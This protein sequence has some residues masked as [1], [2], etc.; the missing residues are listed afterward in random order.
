MI[1]CDCVTAPPA[2]SVVLAV[3]ELIPEIRKTVPISK[4]LASVYWTALLP[5]L[6]IAS[7]PT[8]LAAA[9]KVIAV[10]EVSRNASTPSS[11]PPTP[12]LTLRLIDPA[13][14]WLR[15]PTPL[16]KKDNEPAL[17]GPTFA[18][19]TVMLE[20]PVP[21]TRT[22]DAVIRSSSVSES[23]S[24]LAASVAEPRSIARAVACGL[25]K[26]CWP[27]AEILLFKTIRS[28]RRVMSPLVVLESAS[29]TVSVPAAAVTFRAEPVAVVSPTVFCVPTAKALACT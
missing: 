7:V 25:N 24:A 21:A 14:V 29:V 12:A 11:A 19:V 28:A 2:L 17:F 13:P 15:M 10:L 18:A 8:L 22:R 23:S 26:T 20:A 27:A 3:P 1:A 9:L 6:L 16:V 4:P 5:P